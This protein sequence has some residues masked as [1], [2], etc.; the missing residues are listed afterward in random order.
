MKIMSRDFTTREK[1]LLLVLTLILI[2]AGYY[3]V[4][5]QPVRSAIN[6]AKSQQDELNTDL[7]FFRRKQTLLS[8][9]QSDWDSLKR[10]EL[11]GKW[12]VT[13]TQKQ[14]LMN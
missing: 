14:S 7:C 5:D 3:L 13:T 6:E 11:L 8:R 4:V 1:A 9:M 12:E 10:T 2:C